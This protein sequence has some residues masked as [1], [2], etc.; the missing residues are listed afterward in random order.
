VGFV[1]SALSYIVQDEQVLYDLLKIITASLQ[2]SKQNAEEELKKLCQDEKQQPLTYNH[3][4]TN[5][6]QKSRQ[7]ST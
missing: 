4:Y 3:Y 6:V 2:R 7:N 5:N 1:K